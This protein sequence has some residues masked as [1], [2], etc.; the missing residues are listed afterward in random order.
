LVLKELSIIKEE[1]MC[2]GTVPKVVLAYVH[3]LKT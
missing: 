2:G 1:F 3:G